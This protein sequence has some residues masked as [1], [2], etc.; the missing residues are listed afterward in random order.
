M[1]INCFSITFWFNI[2]D[3]HLKILDRF[4]E[5]VNDEYKNFNINNNSHNNLLMPVITAVNNTK[6]TNF[7]MSHI[8]FQ[9]NM[10]N[11][12]FDDFKEFKDKSLKFFEILK[13][14][15]IEILHTAIFINSEMISEKALEKI[16]TSTLKNTL[17]SNDLVDATLKLGKKEEDLFYKILTILNKKQIKLPRKVDELGRAIPIPLISWN[18]AYV[19]NEI[20]EVSYEMNDKYSF[21]FTKNY[22]TTEFFLNKML[23]LIENNY[24]SDIDNLLD[25]GE[26]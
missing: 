4:K 24:K 26:F 12:T 23:Y 16:T 25:D 13:E 2:F 21:D 7:S 11:V 6:K 9:Y 18:G 20:V 3:D 19:E 10:D 5:N 22:H 8:N 15:K 1:K 14:N 17:K